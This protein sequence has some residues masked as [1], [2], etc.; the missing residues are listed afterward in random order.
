M[1][2]TLCPRQCRADRA[3]RP[4]FC[5]LGEEMRIARIAPHLWEEPPVSGT[6]GTGAVFFSGCTLRCV[7]CQNGEISHTGA[8]RA[9][10]PRELSDA[11]KRLADLGVHTLS[12]ITGT[13]FVPQILDA[14]ELWR[15]PL[16]VVWNT[17]GYET[18]ETLRRLEDAVDVWLPDLKH[19]SARMGQLCAGAPDYFETASAA[20]LE[21]CR[22]AGP[23]RYD[24][25]G[26]MTRGVLVRH[27]IL[28]GLTGESMKLLTWIRD[29]LPAGTPVSL[30][31]QYVP[32]NG[33]SVPGLDRR[34]TEREYRRVRDH[35]Q[36]L[37]LPGFL[38]EADS[39][40]V[41]FIPAFNQPESFV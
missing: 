1:I 41:D 20:I 6:R 5:G 12:L 11:L 15:P 2:C 28:P 23:C 34:V 36:V 40:D 7:Y 32:C 38:Q 30:M 25:D 19:W 33:V 16:P 13:P 29:S 17:S 39:A 3:V 37:G 9:F 14:L 4:G 31:R 21:M 22:Q 24:A 8:G 27:L 18:V 35:M 10:T 26:I